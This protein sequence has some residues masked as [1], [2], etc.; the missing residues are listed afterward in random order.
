MIDRRRACSDWLFKELR[1]DVISYVLVIF[2]TFI[3]TSAVVRSDVYVLD[4]SVFVSAQFAFRVFK[5]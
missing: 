1:A 4:K 2:G 3:I 5:V